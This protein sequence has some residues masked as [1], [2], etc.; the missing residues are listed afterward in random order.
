MVLILSFYIHQKL[1]VHTEIAVIKVLVPT[2]L[3]N[4]VELVLNKVNQYINSFI[5]LIHN[6]KVS[7]RPSRDSLPFAL[8]YTTANER[9][10]TRLLYLKS[11]TLHCSPHF[12]ALFCR[13]SFVI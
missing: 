12:E 10:R 2:L 7:N 6:F 9:A 8:R 13:S 4:K 11:F 5:F 3:K 1:V